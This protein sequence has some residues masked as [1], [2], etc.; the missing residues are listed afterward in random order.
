MNKLTNI[1]IYDDF[2]LLVKT[3]QIEQAI[4]S[5]MDYIGEAGRWN[6]I[7]NTIMAA[8]AAYPTKT[9]TLHG[10]PTQGCSI[11]LA[12]TVEMIEQVSDKCK[13]EV[14]FNE[15]IKSSL[16]TQILK[17]IMPQLVH[18]LQDE[19]TVIR[20]TLQYELD[21]IPQ[22]ERILRECDWGN[23]LP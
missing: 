9:L 15:L 11:L 17:F 23:Q 10:E 8:R 3:G 7:N 22:Y 21:K 20:T 2:T 5:A 4:A 19:A 6:V 18:Q 13:E 12:D 1:D 16:A 14:F